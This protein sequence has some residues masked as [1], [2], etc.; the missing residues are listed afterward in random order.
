M[1]SV[2]CFKFASKGSLLSLP[3]SLPLSLL[4]TLIPS[5]ATLSLVGE[6]VQLKRDASY[7]NRADLK[8][9]LKCIAEMPYSSGLY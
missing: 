5:L 6:E 1:P 4:L 3:P 7:T 9:K 2:H 8:K